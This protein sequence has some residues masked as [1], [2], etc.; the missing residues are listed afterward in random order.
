MFPRILYIQD[1]SQIYTALRNNLLTLQHV[2][3]Y[4]CGMRFVFMKIN[5]WN[6]AYQQI[7]SIKFHSEYIFSREHWIIVYKKIK[8]LA[9][10]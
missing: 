10:F 4:N 6:N 7:W 3:K 8:N 5:Y 2:L 1:F 9:E